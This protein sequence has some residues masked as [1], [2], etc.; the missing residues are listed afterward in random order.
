MKRTWLLSLLIPLSVAAAPTP[1]LEGYYTVGELGIVEFSSTDGTYTG[2]LKSAQQ[3]SNFS[4]D[5]PVI[6]GAFEGNVFVG[7]VAICQDGKSC[8]AKRTYAFLGI[9]Q[10]ESL[11]GFLHL[12]KGCTSLATDHQGIVIRPASEE[13]TRKLGGGTASSQRAD[14]AVEALIREGLALL[15]ERNNPTPKKTAAAQAKLQRAVELDDRRWPAHLGL[16]V[17][18]VDLG[19]AN[20]A[21]PELNRALE[22]AGTVSPETESEIHY[23]RAQAYSMLGMKKEGLAAFRKSV[24]LGGAPMVTEAR[25]DPNLRALRELPDFQRII[26]EQHKKPK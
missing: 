9:Y 1:K 22:L 12:D 24:Q 25:K 21:L 16:G 20:K 15:D 8:E 11:S 3:C 13:E 14:D 6:T 7:T 2:R 19:Q 17:A 23:H 5:E 26:D 10:G 18:L 4:L